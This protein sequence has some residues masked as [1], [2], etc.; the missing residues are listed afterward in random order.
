MSDAVKV[1]C[2][3]RCAAWVEANWL[4]AS[5][6]LKCRSCLYSIRRD[7]RLA[8]ALVDAYRAMTEHGD[9]AGAERIVALL[10]KDGYGGAIQ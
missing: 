9:H 6:I 5:T 1:Y 4:P 2:S 7:D 8:S 10:K 3:R